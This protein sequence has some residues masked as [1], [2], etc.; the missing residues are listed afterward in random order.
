MNKLQR[1]VLLIGLCAVG[2]MLLMPPWKYIALREGDNIERSAGYALIFSPP[3]VKD[4][5]AI[6]AAF[7]IPKTREV[8]YPLSSDN[9]RVNINGRYVDR[10]TPTPTPRFE[11]VEI[12]ESGYE[13]RL[14]TTRLLIQCGVAV[15][16]AL[17]FTAFL[18]KP[19]E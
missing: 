4:H 3:S 5:E 14:D 16:I 11:P 17:G 15:F 13:V 18:S 7:S 2:L 8:R 6:R 19:R 10:P 9:T 12:L 1:I